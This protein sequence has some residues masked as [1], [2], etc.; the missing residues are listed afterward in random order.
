MRDGGVYRA[1]VDAQQQ[2]STPTPAR[3][4]SSLFDDSTQEALQQDESAL[5]ADGP[6]ALLAVDEE[7][8]AASKGGKKKGAA[9]PPKMPKK[10]L[11]GLVGPDKWYFV[12]GLIGAAI[13]GLA[14]PAVGYLMSEFLV[15]FFHE[16]VDTMRSE[17]L[18]WSLVFISF[19][20]ANSLGAVMRQIS[21]STITARM[22]KRVRCAVFGKVVRQHV[23]WFDASVE[24]TAGAIVSQLGTDCFLLQALT[25][26]RA[27]LAVS[28]IIVLVAGLYVSFEASW[29]LTLVVF[30]TIP[31]IVLP[32][33]I[34]AKVVSK[35]SEMAAKSLVDAGH[36]A[37]E[38]ITNL[39]TVA[40]YGLEASRGDQFTKE[41]ELPRQ[42]DVRKGIAV[43]VGGGVAAGA[44]L[45][46]AV[47]AA[48]RTPG[49]QC[50]PRP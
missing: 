19:G 1:L 36:T 48:T 2:A 49:R 16:D 41:L 47:R 20:A 17:S 23:G 50:A 12:P 11:W 3:R 42:Q 25:G 33:G 40:A 30:V 27:S 31:I 46:S 4:S 37:S 6:V 10:W 35:Y 32:V 39:R 18:K 5:E 45:F 24:H 29:R 43:G 21:F 26:E 44:I 14:M 38:T 8:G 13:T 34:S 9:K 7:K 22:V 15:V 28:Q